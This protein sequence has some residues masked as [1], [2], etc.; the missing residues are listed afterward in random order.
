MRAARYAL[1]A[2]RPDRGGLCE[3]GPTTPAMGV[4]GGAFD[5]RVVRGGVRHRKDD[6]AA[7][8]EPAE[9]I[10]GREGAA[11]ETDEGPAEFAP[12]DHRAFERA[13]VSQ[14]GT[15]A[16]GPEHGTV[17]SGSQHG[18]VASGSQHGTVAS[19]SQHR[20]RVD[21]G[22]IDT[23]ADEGDPPAA[24]PPPGTDSDRSTYDGW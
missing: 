10:G 13:G 18:T 6:L 9:S 4:R 7:G 8:G 12:F 21:A 1:Y 14:H 17:A 22:P 5:D 24:D 11:D 23:A 2:N 16:S 3:L 15:V 19:G 20:P